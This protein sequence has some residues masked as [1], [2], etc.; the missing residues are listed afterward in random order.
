[1]MKPEFNLIWYL[2]LL[3][4]FIGCF[5]AFQDF[6]LSLDSLKDLDAQC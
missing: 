2:S 5:W 3:L 1:M 6:E 4:S